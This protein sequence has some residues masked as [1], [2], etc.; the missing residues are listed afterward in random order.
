MKRKIYPLPIILIVFIIAG[1]VYTRSKGAGG[2]K[3]SELGRYDGY[4]QA[5]YDGHVR[6]S[7]YMNLSD[8]TRLAYDLI[9]PTQDGESVILPLPVL[10]KYTPYLRTWTIFDKDGVNIMGDVY[11]LTLPEKIMLRIRYWVYDRGHLMD[12]L[13]RTKWLESMVYH[14]YAVVVVERPGTGASFGVMDPSFEAGAR[15][16]DEILNWIADQG[17]SDGN[18][19]MFGDSWQAQIQFAAASTGNPHLKAIFPVS[20]SLD[21]YSSIIYP[22]GVYNKAFGSLFSQLNSLLEALVTPVDRDIDGT[23]LAQAQEER[24]GSTVGEESQ[25]IFARYPYRDS[26]NSRGERIW[27]EVFGLYPMLDKINRSNIPVYLVNGWFDLFTKDMFLWYANLTVPKCLLVLPYDHSQM[28]GE[29]SDLDVGVEAHRWFD[30]WLRGIENGIMEEP[31]IHYSLMGSSGEPTWQTSDQW[32]PS[33]S[34]AATF[35][36]SEGKTGSMGP[37]NGG[38]L[39]ENKPDSGIGKDTYRIDYTT[40]SGKNSRW[41]AVT[42]SHDYSDF[43]MNDQKALTYTTLPLESDLLVIGHPVVSLW[44]ATDARDLDVFVY[45]AEVDGK[46]RSTYITEGNLRASHRVMSEPPYNNLGYPFYDHFER[47][48]LGIPPGE[49]IQLVFDLLP[50]AYRFSQG[51]RIRVIIAFS[52]ADNFETP[53]LDPVPELNLLRDTAHPSSIVLP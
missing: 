41:A 10:F 18:I 14:G 16:A 40:T 5:V 36:F 33:G 25:E 37:G 15:E 19:G 9:L 34:N 8:G 21:N 11:D 17:W 35:F 38:L 51:S 24:L 27:E 39:Q 52:D 13:F 6:Y 7:D 20:G 32:P 43:H 48:L 53:I 29:S 23:L 3:I 45:L 28:E 44:L 4:S 1:L 46:G 31:S 22:G 49:P 2:E 50:T 30:Y 47:N 42:R 26:L 12:P